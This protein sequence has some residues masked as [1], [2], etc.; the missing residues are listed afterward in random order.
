[1]RRAK[2]LRRV[3]LT[4]SLNFGRNVQVHQHSPQLPPPSAAYTYTHLDM[5][6][7]GGGMS[8]NDPKTQIMRG[9]QQEAA[10]QN[11]RMLV[12]VRLIFFCY[13]VTADDC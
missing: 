7:L 6:S 3:L 13:G 8:V 4:S 5:D 10:M 1:M 2:N 11:A 9:V 12:E